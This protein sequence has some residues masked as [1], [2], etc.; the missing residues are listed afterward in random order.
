MNWYDL[1]YCSHMLINNLFGREK[2]KKEQFLHWL[3]YYYRTGLPGH[4]I[5]NF[6]GEPGS[7][8]ILFFEHIIKPIFKT[9][10][11]I[12]ACGCRWFGEGVITPDTGF[13]C[14]DYFDDQ[15]GHQKTQN[16]I[17]EITTN[18]F[19][20]VR[21]SVQED[22]KFV[23]RANFI[24][25]SRLPIDHPGLIDKTISIKSAKRLGDVVSNLAFFASDLK[26]EARRF[27]KFL[28]GVLLRD[29]DYQL[30]NLP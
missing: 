8:K 29:D 1:P 17:A 19:C 13:I 27:E 3:A 6:Y 22:K 2:N 5:W 4:Q 25:N 20:F 28:Q 15:K 11:R 14:F 10:V 16:K 26:D 18:P 24:I 23:L 21:V 30:R 7:G 9:A 12:D